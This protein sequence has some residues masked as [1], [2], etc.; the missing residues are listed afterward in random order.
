MR[1]RSEKG[2]TYVQVLMRERLDIT[3]PGEKVLKFNGNP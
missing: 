2:K 3:P 1:K